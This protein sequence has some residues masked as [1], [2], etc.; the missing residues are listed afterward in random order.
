LGI[1]TVLIRYD[2]HPFGAARLEAM[3][4]DEG[5]EVGYYPPL[6]RQDFGLR[7]NP[8][9]V[10]GVILMASGEA[11]IAPVSRAVAR[12]KDHHAN[13]AIEVEIFDGSALGS[14]G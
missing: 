8:R 13:K 10:A 4:R 2:G 14:G 9:T 5:L 3:L 12:F 7:L 6:F 11:A 1:D